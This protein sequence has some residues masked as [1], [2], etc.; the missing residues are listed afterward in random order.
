MS[1]KDARTGI[2]HNVKLTR[3]TRLFTARDKITDLHLHQI[4]ASQLAVDRKIENSPVP[5]PMLWIQAKG[6]CLYPRPLCTK[7][8]ARRS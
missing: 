8:R 7:M 5:K 4:A 1:S 6:N 2:R 3:L